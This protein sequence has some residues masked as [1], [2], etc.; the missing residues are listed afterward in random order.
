MIGHRVQCSIKFCPAYSDQDCPLPR[1]QSTHLML[2]VLATCVPTN[3]PPSVSTGSRAGSKSQTSG[4]YVLKQKNPPH[5][6]CRAL[7]DISIC[8]SPVPE[9][10]FTGSCLALL[11]TYTE[12]HSKGIVSQEPLW[13][14]GANQLTPIVSLRCPPPGNST[15]SPIIA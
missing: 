10:A 8:P 14:G 5:Q 2:G 15:P 3:P 1:K 13:R 9:P 6:P 7:D 11:N 12:P 4:H